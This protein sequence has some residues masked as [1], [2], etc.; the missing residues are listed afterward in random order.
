MLAYNA[1]NVKDPWDV[2]EDEKRRIA[3]A[4]LKIDSF[5]KLKFDY[6]AHVIGTEEDVDRVIEDLKLVGAS[7]GKEPFTW[8]SSYLLDYLGVS[9][10]LASSPVPMD[11]DVLITSATGETATFRHVAIRANNM[12]E[13]LKAAA[14]IASTVSPAEAAHVKIKVEKF[15]RGEWSK[16]AL[17]P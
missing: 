4:R 17:T 8:N 16:H 7:V 11:Y 14:H 1:L 9:V 6:V 3:A 15:P 13:V 2:T 10:H 12:T 5:K